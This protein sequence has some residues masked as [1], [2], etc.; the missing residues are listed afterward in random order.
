M[1]L[2][3]P[4]RESVLKAISEFDGLGREEFLLKHGFKHA[5]WWFLVHDGKLYDTK[6]IYGVAVAFENEL[7]RAFREFSGGEQTVVR[8]LRKL[9]FEVRNSPGGQGNGASVDP[10]DRQAWIFQSNPQLYDIAGAVRS[11][12]E[13]NWRVGQGKNLLR[14]G[15]HVY[16]WQSGPGGGVIAEGTVL[17]NPEMSQHQE[18][19][20]FI[21]DQAK[22]S[23]E[24]LRVRISIDHVLDE[25]LL[26][27]ELKQD[28]VLGDLSILRFANATNYK[29]RPE[30]DAALQDLIGGDPVSEE[31]RARR[32][33]WVNQNQTYGEERDGGFLWAP[34][35]NRAG[36]TQA[37][38]DSLAEVR[39]GDAI[40]SYVN[41]GIRA[42][43]EVEQEA[44]DASPPNDNFSA[45]DNDGRRL[46]VEYRDL[47]ASIPLADIPSEWRI[48]DGGPFDRGGGVKQGYLFPLSDEFVA[49]MAD[50]FPELGLEATII[51]PP[52]RLTV[53][54]LRTTAESS[55]FNLRLDESLYASLVAALE[56]GKHVVLTG[57]PGTA[58]TTLAQAVSDTAKRLGV[59]RGY[60]LTTATADW[61]T[62]ET[63]GGLRP[64]GGDRLEFSPGHFLQAIE[65]Q[66]WL[67]ID[68]LNRSQFDRAFGQ[69]FTVLSGQAVTLPYS[70]PGASTPLTLLPQGTDPPSP[71]DDVLRIPSDWRI[72]A[73][74]NVFD[75]SLLFEMSYALMR[76]FAF[77]EVPS[78]NEAVFRALIAEAAGGE[79][80]AVEVAT[81]LLPVR[82]IKDVGP[83][84]YQDIAR[85]S[86]ERMRMDG[87]SGDA[88]KF[89]AFYSY[90]LPQFEGI[91]DEQ[92]EVLL[93][94]L[95]EI[96]GTSRR[97]EIRDTL[98]QVLGVEIDVTTPVP[99]SEGAELEEQA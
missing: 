93:A 21:R 41:G 98:C 15:D 86:A 39:E 17:T 60:L 32:V 45:W 81:A 11:L 82:Q 46:D 52:D 34:K 2:Q 48:S 8:Q 37:H 58:K 49:K 31:P 55:P 9:G 83:A 44:V 89:Q 56:S 28:P 70:R 68:E 20:E 12:Q 92:A 85:F 51:T 7:P 30:Q 59:C 50:R 65:D 40:L 64:V 75:K 54:E 95:S 94:T 77:I 73:T 90:L 88:V 16:I 62:Y 67:V 1:A 61:T 26:R 38:W 5:K 36:R 57:P 53:D 76:R 14:A 72:V 74:M 87:T 69:L 99:A 18:G 13:M 29:I 66:N 84:V 80:G 4:S 35:R 71:S 63:I 22:F 42:V 47:D 27:E 19:E 24:Q 97:E 33:W 43:S 79:V 96:C 6:A 91:S 25:P 23:G 3:G 78:P 10:V